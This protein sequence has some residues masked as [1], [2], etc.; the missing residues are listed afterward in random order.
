[1]TNLFFPH[2]SHYIDLNNVRGF[3][4]SMLGLDKSATFQGKSCTLSI[5]EYLLSLLVPKHQPRQERRLRAIAQAF[6]GKSQWQHVHRSGQYAKAKGKKRFNVAKPQPKAWPFED[7]MT[8]LDVAFKRWC[9]DA[10]LKKV[11]YSSLL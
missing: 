7:L 11:C 1:L 8:F 9:E 2:G 5:P 4:T 3:K 6:L 10:E